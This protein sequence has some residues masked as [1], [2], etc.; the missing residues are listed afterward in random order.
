MPIVTLTSDFGLDSHYTAV[1]KGALHKRVEDVRIVDI[2]HRIRKFDAVE[3][4]FVLRSVYSEF[5]EGSIHLICVRSAET[6]E[7]PHRLVRLD[8]HYFIGADTGV[9]RLLSDKQPE[10]VFDFSGL[11]LDVSAPTFPEREVFVPAAAHLARGGKEDLIGRST[12]GLKEAQP[13]RLSYDDDTLI[14][15]VVYIDDYGNVI[16]NISRTAFKEFGKGRPFEIQLRTSRMSIRK[17]SEHYEDVQVGKE[18]AVFNYAGLLEIAMN[19]HSAPGDRGGADALLGLKR[20]QVVR[21]QFE[22]GTLL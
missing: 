20:D 14:G 4:A 21:V 11:N 13:R 6:P 1:I 15:H 7:S 12:G 2:S 16:T 19:N 5:P 10:G 18:V 9:F 8:G 3:A 22:S 17:V